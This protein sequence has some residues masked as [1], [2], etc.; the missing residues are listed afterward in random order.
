[1]NVQDLIDSIEV[2]IQRMRNIDATLLASM[3]AR[4]DQLRTFIRRGCTGYTSS[5]EFGS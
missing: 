5:S 1:M 3:I 4:L 2:D